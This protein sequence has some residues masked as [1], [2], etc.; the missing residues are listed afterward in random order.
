MPAPAGGGGGELPLSGAGGCPPL[1]ASFPEPPVSGVPLPASAAPPSELPD[2]PCAPASSHPK[3]APLPLR[4]ESTPALLHATA[5]V[6]AIATAIVTALRMVTS[7]ERSSSGS[8]RTR[9]YDFLSSF[10]D[11]AA[12]QWIVIDPA[13]VNDAL[14]R[15]EE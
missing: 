12:Q 5:R 6:A 14:F 4:S 3:P 1:A 15:G 11:M 2:E 9:G 10:A 7:C 8:S 13:R